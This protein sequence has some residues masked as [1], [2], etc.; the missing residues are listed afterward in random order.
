MLQIA[1]NW[2]RGEEWSVNVVFFKL[3]VTRTEDFELLIDHYFEEKFDIVLMNMAIMDVS[4]L[5]PLA[6]ALPKLLKPNGV[7]VATVLHP[8]FMTSGASRNVDLRYDGETGDLEVVR[9]KVI[10]N[11]LH[12]PPY[13]GIA[14]PGQPK[15]QL[16]F[17]RPM[18]ELFTTFFRAGLVMDAM[19]EPAFSEEDEEKSRVESSRNYTQ[20]PAI[21]SFRMRLPYNSR[22]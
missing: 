15:R 18:D 20:L 3:D 16:Y 5:E 8:V 11:Y 2:T 9:T 13:K 19:E 1:R 7:F 10:K 4:T 21:L 6:Q 14:I 22:A 12:V 17:H